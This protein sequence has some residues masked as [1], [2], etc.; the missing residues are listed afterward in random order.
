MDNK[1]E[2]SPEDQQTQLPQ[3]G[4]ERDSGWC[5]T[6]CNCGSTAYELQVYSEGEWWFAGNQ[7][8]TC[9]RTYY[10]ASDYT[11]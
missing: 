4:D 2:N 1:L 10:S 3:E 5:Y 8:R 9:W 6:C 11:Y 7:C